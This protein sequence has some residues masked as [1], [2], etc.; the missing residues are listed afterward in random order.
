[1]IINYYPPCPEPDLTLGCRRHTDPGSITLLLQDQVGGLQATRDGGKTWITVKPVEGAFVVNL[2][3]YGHV[4]QYLSN[5]RFK[6]A[7]HQAVVNST[8][9]RMSIATLQY[10]APDAIVYPL[11]IREGEKPI[12]DEAI[13]FAEM[14]KRNMSKPG[15]EAALRKLA[16]EKRLQ[17]EK[18]KLEMKP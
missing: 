10:P 9:T 5:G 17:E 15:E 7:D 14:Y 11:K 16:K 13:T 3:D 4:M 2:G 1:M 6:S 8:Y 12:V 18:A